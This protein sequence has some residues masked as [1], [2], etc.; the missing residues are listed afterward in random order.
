MAPA[1]ANLML[2]LSAMIWGGSNVAQK[3]VLENIGPLTATGLKCLIAGLVIAPFFHAEL[4]TR[5]WRCCSSP[6]SGAMT[7]TAFIGGIATMQLAYGGTSVINASF[8]INTATIMT[9]VVAWLVTG[10][11]PSGIIW[12]AAVLTLAGIRLM[13][14]EDLRELGWGDAV[15]FLSA[16]FYAVWAVYLGKFVQSSGSPGVVTVLQFLAAG[17]VCLGAGLL[18]EPMELSGLRAA[19]PEL[20]VLGVLSTGLGYLL[21]AIAQ[22]YTA[23]STAAI[24][25]SGEAVF[26][27]LGGFFLLGESLRFSACLGI[28]L[29]GAAIVIVQLPR[30]ARRVSV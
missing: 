7:I 8:L 19:A 24:I 28:A 12:V 29:L 5:W 25:V 20:F 27:A 9:P 4:R 6:F 22:Q 2:L 16:G 3:T 10:A 13:G 11:R 14:G 18:I 26:G 15:C 21:Q 17:G 1:R 23:A 30:F